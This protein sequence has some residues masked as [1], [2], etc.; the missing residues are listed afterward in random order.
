MESCLCFASRCITYMEV[1][2]IIKKNRFWGLSMV[3]VWVGTVNKSNSLGS[4]TSPGSNGLVNLSS[5]LFLSPS[6]SNSSHTTRR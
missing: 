6:L 5:R 4:K 3:Q 1:Q 2:V